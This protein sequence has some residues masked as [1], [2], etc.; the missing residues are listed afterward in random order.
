MDLHLMRSGDRPASPIRSVYSLAQVGS[1]RQRT[2]KENLQLAATGGQAMVIELQGTLDFAGGELLTRRLAGAFDPPR[3]AVLDLRRVDR[4]QASIPRL[5]AELVGGLAERDGA[6]LV[7]GLDHR[8]DVTSALIAAVDERW[9]GHLRTFSDLD[10]ALEW[11][12]AELTGWSHELV[13]GAPVALADHALTEGLTPEQLAR[14]EAITEPRRYPAGAVLAEIGSVPTEIVLLTAGHASVSIDLGEGDM[15]RVATLTAGALLG[16]MAL[17]SH[18]PRVNRVVADS[19]IT[20]L[21]MSADV[22]R[23]EEEDGELRRVL[24][25]N[26]IRIIAERAEQARRELVH[27][28]D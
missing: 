13:L 15:R 20:C 4:V 23:W 19:D 3:F 1:R 12:E 26:L 2:E 10:V 11:C 22:A 27:L 21:V 18:A 24:L 16:E 28:T 7:C 14:V 5:L 25:R 17:V 6:L 8:P 9:R